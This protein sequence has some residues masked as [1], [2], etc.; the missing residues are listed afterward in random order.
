MAVHI[1][2][3]GGSLA[4]QSTSLAAVR[5]ALEGASQ[6]GAH[7]LLD[8]AR[9]ELLEDLRTPAPPC[10]AQ[11]AVVRNLIAQPEAQEPEIV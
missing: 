6:A 3:L 8:A 11:D 7:T 4:E 1:V 5:I 10:F 2:A 9:K